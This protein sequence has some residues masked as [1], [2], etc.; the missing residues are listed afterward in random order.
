[1]REKAIEFRRTVFNVAFNDRDDH[2]KNFSY[3]MA[4]VGE[5]T[6]AL[7]HDVTFCEGS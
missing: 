7:T 3:I 1:M 4:L 5:W 6:L 2:S